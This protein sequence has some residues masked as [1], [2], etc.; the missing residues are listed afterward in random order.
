LSDSAQG[1]TGLV[2]PLDAGLWPPHDWLNL[3]RVRV[4]GL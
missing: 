1:L 3:S 2:T 4:A